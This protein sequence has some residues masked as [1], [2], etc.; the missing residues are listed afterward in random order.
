MQEAG[1][2]LPEEEI[3]RALL[4]AMQAELDE[5]RDRLEAVGEAEEVQEIDEE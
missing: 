4:R 1:R 3:R 2:R 5:A